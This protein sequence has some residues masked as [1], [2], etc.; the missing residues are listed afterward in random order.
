M[1]LTL[2][3]PPRVTNIYV[4]GGEEDASPGSTIEKYATKIEVLLLRV[5][6]QQN[7][8]LL[9]WTCKNCFTVR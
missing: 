9:S 4:S 3:I 7:Y 1:T 6:N 8:L 2:N 5:L